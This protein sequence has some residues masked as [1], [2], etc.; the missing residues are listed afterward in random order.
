M[1]PPTGQAFGR[2]GIPPR[3]TSSSKLHEHGAVGDF[4]P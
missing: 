4:D 2:P 3:W 1:K